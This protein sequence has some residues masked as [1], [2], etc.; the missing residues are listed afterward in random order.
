MVGLAG[1]ERPR[2]FLHT[3]GDE[4]L[5]E[6]DPARYWE[7]MC[8]KLARENSRLMDR[9]WELENLL[10]W[11]SRW[12]EPPPTANSI[13]LVTGFNFDMQRK[14]WVAEFDGKWPAN[15]AVDHWRPIGE[16]PTDKKEGGWDE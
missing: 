11:R 4:M 15:L 10:R 12:D 9:C 5:L 7:M 1:V 16:L 13:Y 8:K 14:F 2:H 3:R 6:D